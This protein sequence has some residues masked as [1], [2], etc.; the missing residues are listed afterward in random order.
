M[1]VRGG[2]LSDHAGSGGVPGGEKLMDI[3][4]S[5][6]RLLFSGSL[7]GLHVAVIQIEQ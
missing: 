7:V 6:V 2:F 4:C 1:G 5:L 3:T